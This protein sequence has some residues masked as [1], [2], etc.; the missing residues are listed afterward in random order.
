[1]A[2]VLRTCILLLYNSDGAYPNGG[3][4]LSGNILYGTAEEGGSNSYGT[5]FA[6]NTSGTGFTVLHSFLYTRDGGYPYGG[7][8]LSGNTL[9]GT[10]LYG[11]TNSYGTVF[12]LTTSSLQFT[13][14]P[15]AGSAPL[16]VN[17]SSPGVDGFGNAITSWNWTFGDGSTSAA[18]NPSHTYTTSGNF[19]PSLTVTNSYGLQLAE[20]GPSITVSARPP[21]WRSPPVQPAAWFHSR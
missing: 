20:S 6:I 10:A 9:F 15:T 2:R 4:T 1:M 18:Q 5:V 8:T 13:A 19:S 17:F 11:G 12:A 3:L 7:L 16:T 14:N 21:P